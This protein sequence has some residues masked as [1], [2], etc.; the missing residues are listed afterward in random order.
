MASILSLF[1]KFRDWHFVYK[2]EKQHRAKVRNR[3]NGNVLTKEQEK[4]IREF[5]APY[6]KVDLGAHNFYTE[7]T[8][9]FHVNY[10]PDDF[11]YSRIDAY[12]NDWRECSYIDNKCFYRRIFRGIQQPQDIATRT[13]GL[14]YDSNYQLISRDAL[15][16]LLA[17]EPEIVTK[18]AR[19]C[20]G[21]RGVRFLPGKDF[22]TIEDKFDD[23]IVIQRPLKQHAGLAAINPNSVNTIRI[24]SLLSQE[25][26]KIYS[27]ILRIGIGGARVDNASAG[28]ITCG[29]TADGKLKKY[30]YTVKGQ[31]FEQHP[32]TGILFENTPIPGFDLCMAAVPQLHVQIPRFHLVSWDFAVDEAGQPILI[33]PNMHYGEVDFHQ[34]N[35]GPIFGDDTEKILKMVFGDP[36]AK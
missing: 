20:G 14:W 6:G 24:V 5:F 11:Y 27:A 36:K 25:G 9:Q 17:S 23:D 22:S 32:T 21:G 7:K 2:L 8:G 4:Q 28:G 1:Y 16:D 31:R 33:E 34:L 26:V 18:V 30:A 35:N 3:S 12:F 13:G 10:M 15:E 19:S 29:I